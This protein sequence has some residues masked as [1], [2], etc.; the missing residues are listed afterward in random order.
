MAQAMSKT[1]GLG[2]DGWMA[3]Y[4]EWLPVD[5]ELFSKED[6][7]AAHNRYPVDWQKL[8]ER[9]LGDDQL[10]F[11]RSGYLGSQKIAHQV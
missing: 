5:A 1:L 3:D 10:A 7:E 2:F 8:N 6:A 11:V 4:G 9:V